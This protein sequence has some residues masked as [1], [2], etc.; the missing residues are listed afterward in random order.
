MDPATI[1]KGSEKLTRIFKR[2]PSFHDSEVLSLHLDR[3]GENA[4]ALTMKV[5]WFEGSRDSGRVARKNRAIATF[6]FKSVAG[7][8]IDGF[9]NQNAVL[10][11]AIEPVAP[12]DD[13]VT[14]P[15]TAYRVTIGPSHGLG[16]S[17]T[18]RSIEV[19]DVERH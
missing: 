2:W 15:G 17:F 4:P 1:V 7:L 3:E 19:V 9:N 13:D 11:L 16:G 6:K 12:G 10:D 14:W 18:C 8:E 5:R